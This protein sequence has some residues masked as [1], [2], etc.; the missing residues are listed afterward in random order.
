MGIIYESGSTSRKAHEQRLERHIRPLLYSFTDEPD[1]ITIEIRPD[2]QLAIGGVEI[3]D[4]RKMSNPRISEHGALAIDYGRKTLEID[5][6]IRF[7]TPCNRVEQIREWSNGQFQVIF[8][9]PH[10]GQTDQTAQAA[11]KHRTRHL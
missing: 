7:L 5:F 11:P 6:G 4:S 1:R 8:D 3:G 9:A 10:P 2:W